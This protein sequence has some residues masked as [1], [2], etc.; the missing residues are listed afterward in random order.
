MAAKGVNEY[1][2]TLYSV[3]IQSVAGADADSMYDQRKG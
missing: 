2:G 3:G 1:Q